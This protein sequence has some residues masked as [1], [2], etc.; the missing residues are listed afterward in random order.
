[1][2]YPP[3]SVRSYY[4]MGYIMQTLQA[5][6]SETSALSGDNI[7]QAHSTLANLLLGQQDS[8]LMEFKKLSAARRENDSNKCSC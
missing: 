3:S 1:M 5:M 2:L 6:F 8:D 4:H 7:L